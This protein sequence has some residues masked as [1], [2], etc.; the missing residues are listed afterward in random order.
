MFLC[1]NDSPFHHHLQQRQRRS[2]KIVGERK[3]AKNRDSN[4]YNYGAH[5]K[6]LFSPLNI[7]FTVHTI[8]IYFAHCRI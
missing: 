1:A 8:M 2:G 7:N 5:T 4:A 6:N 3:R